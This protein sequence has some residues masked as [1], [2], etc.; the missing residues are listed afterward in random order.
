MHACMH[1]CMFVCLYVYMF[2]CIVCIV[3][4]CKVQTQHLDK[5]ICVASSPIDLASS[6]RCLGF[7]DIRHLVFLGEGGFGVQANCC[8]TVPEVS[9]KNVEECGGEVLE[10]QKCLKHGCLEVLSDG[11]PQIVGNMSSTACGQTFLG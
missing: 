4:K 11:N 8:K 7:R 5:N 3:G 9:G 10:K 2:V 1:V 6:E